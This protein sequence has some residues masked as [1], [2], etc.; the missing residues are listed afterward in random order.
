MDFKQV[1]SFYWHDGIL[2]NF[3]FSLSDIPSV[4]ISVKLYENQNAVDR[5]SVTLQFNDVEHTSFSVNSF[6][7]NDNQSAGNISNAYCKKILDSNRFQFFM[8]L[9]DGYI[10]FA[11]KTAL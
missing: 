9:V 2:T 3:P 4:L 8:Y 11:F 6:E 10:S 7:L 1:E 5:K